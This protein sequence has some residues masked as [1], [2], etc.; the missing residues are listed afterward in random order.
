MSGPTPFSQD[1]LPLF[2][3]ERPAVVILGDLLVYIQEMRRLY[4]DTQEL[5]QVLQDNLSF[6]GS[7]SPK[8]VYPNLT[9]LQQDFPTG[10]SHIY[11]T[12]DNGNWYYWNGTVWVSGGVYQASTPNNFSIKDYQL[13]KEVIKLQKAYAPISPNNLGFFSKKIETGKWLSEN[14]SLSI[15]L[16]NFASYTNPLRFTGTP[17]SYGVLNGTLGNQFTFFIRLNSKGFTSTRR[18][19]SFQRASNAFEIATNATGNIIFSPGGI[20]TAAKLD[21]N[22][23]QVLAVSVD[24]VLKKAKVFVDGVFI[25]SYDLSASSNTADL[26]LYIGRNAQVD[27]SYME[28]DVYK[29]SFYNTLLSDEQIV[30]ESVNLTKS[31]DGILLLNQNDLAEKLTSVLISHNNQSLKSY[32]DSLENKAKPT[33]KKM[34]HV[35]ADDV[36]EIFKDLQTNNRTS[37]FQNPSLAFLKSMHVQYGL[38]FSGY[39]FYETQDLS[40]NLSMV[41]NQFQEEFRQNASWL[42]FGYHYLNNAGGNF[43]NVDTETGVG[44]YTQGIAE[45]FR[46]CGGFESIDTVPRFHN[47]ACPLATVQA[48]QKLNLGIEGFLTSEDSR[49]NYHL[50]T[51][52]NNYMKTHDRL[53]DFGNNVRLFSTD[54]RLENT[55]DVTTTLNTR[56]TDILYGGR[57]TDLVIFTHE[58]FLIDGTALPKIQ[59]CCEFAKLNNYRFDFPMYNL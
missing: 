47:Y 18:I 43:T 33:P 14:T 59:E 40:F 22:M 16:F 54:I 8:G 42:K 45:L 41:G 51:E 2:T 34:M 9:M 26:P 20:V 50:T 37:I 39:C 27:G 29:V 13:A 57:M 30:N 15:N 28:A 10:D 49:A 25:G 44:Y 52:Q 32:L 58:K 23:D 12:T 55:A 11:V 4:D 35:S 1:G 56:K 3:E 7:G 6:I 19:L 24:N 38:T 46:I 36:I 21:L 53:T 5:Y 17:K 31:A 48:L